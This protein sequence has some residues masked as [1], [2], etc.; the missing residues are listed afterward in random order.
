MSMTTGPCP[1]TSRLLLEVLD[2][3]EAP[4]SPT[5]LIDRT[6]L[7]RRAMYA[8]L[9]CLSEHSMVR[10]GVSLRD[11]RRR[12]Y[13]IGDGLDGGRWRRRWES[14]IGAARGDC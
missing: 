3:A 8:A 7:K 10:V 2:E 14:D 11:A 13:V 1:A 4:L 12:R 5:D 9:Q 6:G